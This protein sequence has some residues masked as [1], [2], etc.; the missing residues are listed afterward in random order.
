MFPD[1]E[2]EYAS[3]AIA[4][5]MTAA[6]EHQDQVASVVEHFRL[7]QKLEAIRAQAMHRN[8]GH[9]RGC[10]RQEPAPQGLSVFGFEAHV[11]VREAERSFGITVDRAV[12]VARCSGDDLAGAVVSCAQEKH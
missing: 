10:C 6:V 1:T 7:V 3:A 4:H 5:P 11:F 2:T 8:H 9:I 12:L